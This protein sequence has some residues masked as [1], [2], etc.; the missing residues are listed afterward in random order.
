M[1]LK[2]SLL[3]AAAVAVLAACG[4]GDSDDE[5]VTDSSKSSA[6]IVAD[7]EANKSVLAATSITPDSGFEEAY[8][9]VAAVGDSWRLQVNKT[10]GKARVKLR[11]PSDVGALDDTADRVVSISESNNQITISSSDGNLNVKV[12]ARTKNVTGT[13]KMNKAG[14]GVVSS[15]VA[16]SGYQVENKSK[17]AGDYAFAGFAKNQSNGQSPDTVAGTFRISSDGTTL[18][19]CDAGLI[20]AGGT[21]DTVVAGATPGRKVLTL[22]AASETDVSTFKLSDGDRQFG[23]LR[24]V[25]SD[26][27]TTLLIDRSGLNDE[28]TPVYRI[29]MFGARKLDALTGNEFNGTWNCGSGQTF[30]VSGTSVKMVNGNLS[31][32]LAYNKIGVEGNPALNGVIATFDEGGTYETIV[33]MSSSFAVVVNHE[34]DEIETCHRAN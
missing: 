19:I 11:Q 8:D 13:V 2:V 5:K 27:G 6:S 9:L 7:F 26:L 4:G 32:T 14:G 21:C 15:A 30:A 24:A 10:S 28:Q 34:Q 33:P 18:T 17:L 29:G 1:N 31:S 3:G 16:G 12:D 23:F 20:N 25:P 22:A